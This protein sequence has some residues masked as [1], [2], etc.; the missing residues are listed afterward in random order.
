MT[1]I[2]R[3]LKKIPALLVTIL[4]LTA[5]GLPLAG[6]ATT[7]TGG[8]QADNMPDPL[9]PYNRAMFGVNDVIDRGIIAPSARAYRATVPQPVRTGIRNFLHNLHS[10]V[11]IANQILQ[12]DFRGAASD[13]GRFIINTTL[14]VGGLVDVAKNA[15]MTYEPEDFGQ[16]LGKWGVG[17]GAYFVLPVMG[18]S[19]LR[20]ATGLA[21]DSFIDPVRIYL[22]NIHEEGWYYGRAVL[23]GLDNREEL[24][25]A[26][27]DLRRNSFDYYA[28]IRSAYY[29]QRAALVNDQ[30]PTTTVMPAI[31][32]YSDDDDKGG[33]KKGKKDT[34]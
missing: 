26:L 28:A 12:G 32:D 31:P 15:G 3:E 5:G 8:E 6:C 34:N 14:G 13:T 23:A 16:T 2:K 11:N 19:S 27:D 4:A 25:D 9:E 21:V 33:G 30:N 29:Q 20:D 24:L 10:P 17:H 7:H 18:P 1:M 22:F